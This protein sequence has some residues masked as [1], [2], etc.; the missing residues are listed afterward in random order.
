MME[1]MEYVLSSEGVF[2]FQI[3]RVYAGVENGLFELYESHGR[4][5][6]DKLQ[7]LFATLKRVAELEKELDQFKHTLAAF[8][9][10]LTKWII[11]FF[12]TL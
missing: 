1:L 3:D 7:Q 2:C 5:I 12:G 4:L 9:R 8:C 6:E 10:E 11:H